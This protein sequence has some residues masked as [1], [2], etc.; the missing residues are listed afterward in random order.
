MRGIRRNLKAE[1]VRKYGSQGA[2]CKQADGRIT[3]WRLSR[4]I[5][6]LCDPTDDEWKWISDVLGKS[7]RYLD[8][9]VSER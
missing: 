2:F 9:I 8:E 4:I 3:E 5:G 7:V 6:G 1:I